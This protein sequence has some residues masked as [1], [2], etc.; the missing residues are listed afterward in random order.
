MTF[1]Y[2]VK[3]YKIEHPNETY[4]LGAY[5]D[6]EKAKLA[7]DIE[8][9]WQNYKYEPQLFTTS[10]DYVDSNKEKKCLTA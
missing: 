1:I 7:A 9:K 10:V 6:V 2:L 5:T 3:M 4:I 8:V